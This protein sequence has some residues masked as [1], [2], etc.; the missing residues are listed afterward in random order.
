MPEENFSLWM[1][2]TVFLVVTGIQAY[3]ALKKQ[4]MKAVL[5]FSG[6]IWIGAAVYF[7]FLEKTIDI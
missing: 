4:S 6:V 5:L 2:I 1:L 7:V 3:W